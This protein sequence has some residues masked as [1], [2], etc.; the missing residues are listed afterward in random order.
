MMS[1][2][3]ADKVVELQSGGW[4]VVA[5]IPTLQGGPVKMTKDGKIIRVLSDGTVTEEK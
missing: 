4:V 3:Q 2:T 1:K 5:S